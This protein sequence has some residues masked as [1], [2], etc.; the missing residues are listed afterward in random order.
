MH[1][2]LRLNPSTHIKASCGD[3]C[4]HAEDGDRHISEVQ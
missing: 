4:L 2:N 3:L 1:E